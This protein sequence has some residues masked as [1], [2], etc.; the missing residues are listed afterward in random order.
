MAAA[1]YVMMEQRIIR[2][3]RLRRRRGDHALA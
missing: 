3:L 2:C 1:I